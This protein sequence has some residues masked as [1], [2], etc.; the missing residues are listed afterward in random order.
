M[1]YKNCVTKASQALGNDD[2]WLSMI[3]FI[4]LVNNLYISWSWFS[5][6]LF[7]IKEVMNYF[8]SLVG[9]H[10]V[11]TNNNKISKV[12]GTMEL[13]GI[14]RVLKLNISSHCI[15]FYYT[16]VQFLIYLNVLYTKWP[17]SFPISMHHIMHLLYNYWSNLELTGMTYSTREE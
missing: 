13:K 11:H 1:T 17:I 3:H 7:H 10:D 8:F 12:V 4:A 14:E 6:S 9:N 15:L 5:F 2:I 16:T